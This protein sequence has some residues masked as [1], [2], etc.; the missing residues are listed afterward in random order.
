MTYLSSVLP[1][2]ND[3]AHGEYTM[4]VCSIGPT[5]RRDGDKV[6][7]EVNEGTNVLPVVEIVVF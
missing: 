3:S 7:A 4:P 1:L 5:R 6:V 2:S